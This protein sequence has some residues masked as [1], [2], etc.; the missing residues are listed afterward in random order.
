MTKFLNTTSQIKKIET[1]FKDSKKKIVIISPYIDL[2]LRVKSELK[3]K[4]EDYNIELIVI[5]RRDENKSEIHIDRK[6]L[7]FFKEFKNVKIGCSDHLHA[8]YYGNENCG[9]S[10]SLN[11]L[12]SSFNNNSEIGIYVE[13]RSLLNLRDKI[14]N[15]FDDD[16]GGHIF[17]HL[18]GQLQFLVNEIIK[19]ADIIFDRKTEKKTLFGKKGPLSLIIKDRTKEIFPEKN[20]SANNTSTAVNQGYCIRTKKRIPFNLDAPYS[21]GAYYDWIKEGSNKNS[22]E[23]HCHQT[24][25]VS[26]GK[27]SFNK[28]IL[29]IQ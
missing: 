25:I 26:D 22:P 28:P 11:L 17:P 10:T 5:F 21:P 29:E 6:D 9:L 15:N 3:L 20:D 8:K 7:E 27:T 2:P 23:K 13:K 4:T 16:L 1:I 18:Y 12:K 24:G 14:D 19:G